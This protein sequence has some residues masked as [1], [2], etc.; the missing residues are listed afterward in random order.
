MQLELDNLN[1]TT[2]FNI[3]KKDK[4]DKDIKYINT[5]IYAKIMDLLCKYINKTQIIKNNKI[6]Y[7]WNPNYLKL[8]MNCTEYDT[9]YTVNI[10]VPGSIYNSNEL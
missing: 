5:E 6:I 1:Y 9:F 10:N 3:Y 4:E 2:N 8:E 7:T